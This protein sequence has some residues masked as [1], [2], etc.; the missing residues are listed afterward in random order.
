MR[1]VDD[2]KSKSVFY[3][4]FKIYLQ[5]FDNGDYPTGSASHRGSQ[6][7]FYLVNQTVNTPPECTG[8]IRLSAPSVL[9]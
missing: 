3:S 7:L 4:G 9:S 2:C 8:S 5:L 6:H 1:Q